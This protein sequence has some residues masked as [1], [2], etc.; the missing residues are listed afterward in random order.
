[1]NSQDILTNLNT[2]FEKLFKSVEG[3]VYKT[4]DKIVLIGPDILKEEPLKQIFFE[5][6][7]NGIIIIANTLI[8][9]YII[10]YAFTQLISLYNG[11]KVENVYYFI[12]KIIIVGIL[13][14]CSYFLCEQLL[15]LFDGLSDAINTFAKNIVGKE[16]TFANLKE[17]IL[18]VNDF[19]KS[20]ILSLDGIIK[21]L[22]S[23]GILGILQ[24]FLLCIKANK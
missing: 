14:N 4:L 16:A 17:T 1:M 13:V 18:S 20:D 24:I 21:G 12:L 3:E 19:M 6:K 23:F 22:V 8:L 7:E 10:Y 2:V 5:N 11:N 15:T 9:F